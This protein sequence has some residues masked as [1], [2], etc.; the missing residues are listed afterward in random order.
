MQKLEEGPLTTIDYA[1]NMRKLMQ[2]NLEMEVV[3]GQLNSRIKSLVEHQEELQ[4]ASAS[5]Q[6]PI[7]DS[8]AQS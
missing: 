1:E 8:Q 5:K 4:R 3:I 6:Q 2:R 7:P